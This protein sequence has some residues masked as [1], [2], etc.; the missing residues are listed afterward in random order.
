MGAVVRAVVG[1]VVETVAVATAMRSTTR[2]EMSRSEV[3]T[4]TSSTSA[5]TAKMRP[6]AVGKPEIEVHGSATKTEAVVSS[7]LLAVCSMGYRQT[8]ISRR[9]RS[10][11][12]VSFSGRD[13]TVASVPCIVINISVGPANQPE[14]RQKKPT[15]LRALINMA[16]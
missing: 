10:I 13:P 5:P 11:E 12:H 1:A 2:S 9:P 16:Y 15:R 7:H 4:E 6:A 3:W 8:M 14:S